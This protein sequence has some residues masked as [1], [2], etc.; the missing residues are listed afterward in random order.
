MPH[1]RRGARWGLKRR[2]SSDQQGIRSIG[3]SLN[4]CRITCKP[5]DAIHPKFCLSK[6]GLVEGHA[7]LHQGHGFEADVGWMNGQASG[8]PGFR[9]ALPI[10]ENIIH[11]R[12]CC[13]AIFRTWGNPRR[14]K[15]G[16][17][18]WQPH[19]APGEAGPPGPSRCPSEAR[20]ACR[21]R[22]AS[23]RDGCGRRG[24]IS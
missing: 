8:F 21:L 10:Q 15:A 19:R 23:M 9:S 2:R 1:W 4:A 24:A 7:P 18:P 12:R 20:F 13:K 5:K 22:R 6:P 14:I 16:S 11:M 17:R 3:G